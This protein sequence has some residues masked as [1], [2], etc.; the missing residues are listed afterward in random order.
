MQITLSRYKRLLLISFIPLLISGA[1]LSYFTSELF[2]VIQCEDYNCRSPTYNSSLYSIIRKKHASW[3]DI[4]LADNSGFITTH[5]E[6]SER[7]VRGATVLQA[8]PDSARE[9]LN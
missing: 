4:D 3:F 2:L 6:G 9:G 8:R 1:V 7:I 5:V